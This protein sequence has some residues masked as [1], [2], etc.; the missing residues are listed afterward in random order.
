[1]RQEFSELEMLDD[2]TTLRYN[3]K[4]PVSVVGECRNDL[5]S[6]FCMV[7]G[8]KY[9]PPKVHRAICWKDSHSFHLS[10]GVETVWIV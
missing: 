7:R 6:A 10:D 5:I 9:V 2:I 4:L 8:D 1:L 3:G